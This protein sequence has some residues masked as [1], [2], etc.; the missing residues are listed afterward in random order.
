MLIR[1][2]SVQADAGWYNFVVALFVLWVIEVLYCSTQLL[3]KP[4]HF[5][6]KHAN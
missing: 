6:R 5:L 4:G 3:E 2:N 1:T